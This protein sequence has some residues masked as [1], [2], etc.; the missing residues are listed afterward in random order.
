MVQ[1]LVRL[2]PPASDIQNGVDDFVDFCA[3]TVLGRELTRFQG[4]R[5]LRYTTGTV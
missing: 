5:G 1:T 2:W 4:S 3:V